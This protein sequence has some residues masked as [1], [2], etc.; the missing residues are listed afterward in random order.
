MVTMGEIWVRPS[1]HSSESPATG[2]RDNRAGDWQILNQDTDP[3]LQPLHHRRRGCRG[4]V[5]EDFRGEW[6]PKEKLPF[7]GFQSP[8]ELLAEKFSTALRRYSETSP[9]Q[10]F[11][12]PRH[13]AGPQ[14]WASRSSARRVGGGERI[15]E[16]GERTGHRRQLIA[17]FRLAWEARTTRCRSARG[18]SLESREIQSSTTIHA[19]LGCGQHRHAQHESSWANNPVGLVWMT[20]SKPHYGLHGTPSPLL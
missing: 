7:S 14:C 9:D 6:S 8:V 16:W 17:W 3:A 4:S 1:R 13:A 18:R 5:Y 20:L 10:R 12:T 15:G 19:Y 2:K 11:D